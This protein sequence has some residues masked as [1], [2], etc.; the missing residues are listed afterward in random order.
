[1]KNICTLL[2]LTV[3]AIGA[4]QAQI[5]LIG[6]EYNVNT[7]QI[8]ILRWELFDSASVSSSPSM[9]QSYLLGSAVFDAFN[10]NYYLKG[11]GLNDSSGLY[12]LNTLTGGESLSSIGSFYNGGSEIDM[13][14]G[15][16]FNLAPDDVSGYFGI[17]AY[18]TSTGND[19]L[20][21]LI[22]EP[23]TMGVIADATCYDSNNGVFYFVGYD[24][25]QVYSLFSVS[26]AA[27]AFAYTKVPLGVSA[28]VNI[29]Q[30]VNYDNVNNRIYALNIAYDLTGTIQSNRVVEINKTTGALTVKGL[31]NGYIAF[32][33]GASSFDQASSNM[34]FIGIDS[35][36]NRTMIAFDMDSSTMLTGF[37]PQSVTEVECDNFVFARSTYGATKVEEE[38]F[39]G[40]KVFPNPTADRFSIEMPG[41]EG[42]VS[43]SLYNMEGK[44]CWSHSTRSEVTEFSTGSLSQG[45]Y[46][47]RL[48]HAKGM[49]RYT[50]VVE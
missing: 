34:V 42:E 10:S 8:D 32:Q 20:L 13:A 19:T 40:V 29:F 46:Q 21:G 26:L 11:L 6:S 37:V 39:R 17:K 23:I 36:Y 28:P 50:L 25:Q 12:T 35:A 3:L 48:L 9:L 2:V 22:N 33:N 49:Q 44:L 18:D 1:M 47:L 30:N 15:I 45:I 4:S 31:I 5:R 7:G 43:I 14:T 16:I 41:L 38:V 27:P 24:A